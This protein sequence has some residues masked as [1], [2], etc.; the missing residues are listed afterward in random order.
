M[1]QLCGRIEFEK[2]ESVRKKIEYLQNYKAKSVKVSKQHLADVDVFSII[3]RKRYCLCKLF[4][5]AKWH[6]C[7]NSNNQS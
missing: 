4:D 5:G 3:K 6:N 1:K 2:A 7:A